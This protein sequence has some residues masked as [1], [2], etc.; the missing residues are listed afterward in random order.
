MNIRL[1]NLPLGGYRE[2]T[3]AEEKELRRQIGQEVAVAKKDGVK[4]NGAKKPGVGQ[5]S[6]GSRPYA[7]KSGAPG[8]KRE[9]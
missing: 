8:K 1:G 9:N 5:K 4:K 6:Q 2:L 3:A 7:K